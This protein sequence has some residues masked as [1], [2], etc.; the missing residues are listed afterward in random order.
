MDREEIK[1]LHQRLEES[2]KTNTVNADEHLYQMSKSAGW[3]VFE[4]IA[5]NMMAELL[6]PIVFDSSVPMD[7]RGS[8]SDARACSLEAIRK[9]IGIVQSTAKAK[10]SQINEAV[11]TS[12]SEKEL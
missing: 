12:D 4:G 10:Q 9:L 1:I 8:I 2:L 5:M 3:E 7:V 6:E 11:T